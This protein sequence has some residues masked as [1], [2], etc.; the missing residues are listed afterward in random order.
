MLKNVA[1]TFAEQS[2]C[3]K[4]FRSLTRKDLRVLAYHGFSLD[5]EH[6]WAPGV[7]MR[8]RVFA[9]R[10][11]YLK[12]HS[13]P[14]LG[15]EEA[16]SLQ[17]EGKLP[18][19]ATVITIDDGWY[20]TRAIAHPLLRK[21]KFPYTLYVS[22][23]YVEKQSPVFNM[24]VQYMMWKSARK[25]FS[26]KDLD[27]ENSQ[28]FVLFDKDYRIAAADYIIDY[29]D[30]KLDH[31]GRMVLL[32][33][34]GKVLEVDYQKIRESRQL[35]YLNAK[36][37]RKMAS[38]GAD[39]QLHTHRHRFSLSE[40][41]AKEEICQ[42]RK[43]LEKITSRALKHFAYPSGVWHPQNFSQLKKMGI[44]SAVTADAGFN[45]SDND[46]LCIRR[47]VD[48]DNLPAVVFQGEMNGT[49]EVARRVRQTLLPLLPQADYARS[50]F[51]E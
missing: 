9:N 21:Y 42:N 48:F 3:A 47:F 44:K 28:V 8:A 19:G 5:D 16:L 27:L 25:Q 43:V 45:S 30:R 12:D 18:E 6:L 22:S 2:K 40:D 1:L 32:E 49:L 20:S 37:L 11:R 7:F 34:L 33:K 46:L 23:Y 4:L 15:L 10:L 31:Q 29:G 36:E 35:S 41:V 51:R 50:L 39:I 17:G 14:V 26:A 38:D 13:Y 24:V